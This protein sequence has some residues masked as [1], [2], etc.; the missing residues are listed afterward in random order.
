MHAVKESK[1]LE[2]RLIEF[3]EVGRVNAMGTVDDSFAVKG[4]HQRRVVILRVVGCSDS[5][6][7][8]MVRE[9]I[10]RN[11]L[12]RFI[13]RYIGDCNDFIKMFPGPDQPGGWLWRKDWDCGFQLRQ[14]SLVA[15]V[16]EFVRDGNGVNDGF[17]VVELRNDSGA[18]VVAAGDGGFNGM[19]LGA[20]P[21]C[22][23][24]LRALEPWV[25]EDVE[26]LRG[27][28]CGD[29]EVPG[30]VGVEV[31][32]DGTACGRRDDHGCGLR[33]TVTKVEG[34]L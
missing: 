17:G 15:M 7:S 18:Q 12:P 33:R 11:F 13:F 19:L 8:N 5:T 29:L 24:G 23:V 1:R 27:L 3:L 10:A 21:F 34:F 26:G 22:D 31:G 4:N 20:E 2:T 28:G 25:D 16:G 32:E 30:S 6:D 9:G 14:G